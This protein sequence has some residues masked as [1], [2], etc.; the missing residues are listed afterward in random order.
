[1]TRATPFP[2]AA[3][4]TT[5]LEPLLADLIRAHRDW[6]TAIA[7]HRAAISAADPARIEAALTQQRRSIERIAG[8]ED[9]RRTLVTKTKNTGATLRELALLLDPSA[10]AR[11]LSGADELKRLVGEVRR[12]QSVVRAASASL[13][14]HARGVVTQVAAALN[15]A[16]V[17]G[18]AGR[19][20]AGPMVVSSLDI[21]R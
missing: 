2:Q 1:M 17:Y 13:L 9:E 4:I 6:L 20:E 5:D 12:E 11:V 3:S 15:H 8:L 16:G 21:R 10:R 7:E 19:V 14:A 18:R